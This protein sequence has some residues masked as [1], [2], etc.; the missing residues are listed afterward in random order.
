MKE[1]TLLKNDIKPSILI[2]DLIDTY[3][4]T[5]PESFEKDLKIYSIVGRITAIRSFGSLLLFRLSRMIITFKFL[6][7]KKH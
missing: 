5:D 1:L 6:F 3:A 7:Q 2:I 4:G